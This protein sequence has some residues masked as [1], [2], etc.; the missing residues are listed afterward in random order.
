MS[1]VASSREQAE[2]P[3][4]RDARRIAQVRGSNWHRARRV[5]HVRRG[6]EHEQRREARA[7]GL[8]FELSGPQRRGAWAAM[9]MM[10]L[11]ASRPKCPA[12][13]GPLERRVMRSPTPRAPGLKCE[14]GADG[15]AG[16]SAQ[17]AARP[18]EA[19]ELRDRTSLCAR[20]AL[21]AG[22]MAGMR[23][24][25]LWSDRRADAAPE[26]CHPVDARVGTTEGAK[27]RAR[28]I[29]F[30]LSGPQREG[31]WAAERMMTLDA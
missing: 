31:A 20:V 25:R 26:G 17:M 1:D 16:C 23:S 29:T 19:A 12:G 7:R 24:A 3:H 15:P 13:G 8:T 14:D 21:L 30:E 6:R 11:A 4:F 28:R 5:L 2:R 27:V 10:T 18:V 22:H 9:R